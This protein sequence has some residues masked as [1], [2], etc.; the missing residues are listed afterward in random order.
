[1]ECRLEDAA[2]ADF[3]SFK[4]DQARAFFDQTLKFASEAGFNPTVRC[5]AGTIYGVLHMVSAGL[6]VAI[7]PTSSASVA[8]E[9]VRLRRLVRPTRPGSIALV[10]R[11]VDR[12]PAIARL[13]VLIRESFSS[14]HSLIEQK[15]AAL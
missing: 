5:E 3:I 4:R 14:L 7:V 8:D 6:G 13:T 10:T 15:L 11:R 1:M 2:Q 9:R 12:D